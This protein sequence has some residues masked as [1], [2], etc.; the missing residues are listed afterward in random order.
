MRFYRLS[1]VDPDKDQSWRAYTI[2]MLLFS[3]AGI[4]LTYAIQR[5]QWYLPLNSQGFAGVPAPVAFN[6]AVS[7]ITNTNWQSYAGEIDHV[8][9]HPDGRASRSTTSCPQR[10]VSRSPSR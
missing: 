7:F 8:E 6:T 3:A 2:G 10:P 4:F 5:L 1:G 9:L